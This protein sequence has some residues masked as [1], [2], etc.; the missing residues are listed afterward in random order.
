MRKEQKALHWRNFNAGR[1]GSPR[2]LASDRKRFK[3]ANKVVTAVNFKEAHPRSA[4]K[5]RWSGHAR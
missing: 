2:K 5:Q 3:V 4:E 1:E